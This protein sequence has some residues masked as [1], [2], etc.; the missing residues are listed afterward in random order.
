MSLHKCDV[1]H[2]NKGTE[3]LQFGAT[4]LVISE[5]GKVITALSPGARERA[6]N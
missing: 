2:V 3:I 4:T 6:W 1:V 5:K